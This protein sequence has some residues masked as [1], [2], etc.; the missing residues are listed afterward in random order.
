[1]IGIG[2]QVLKWRQKSWILGPFSD[3]MAKKWNLTMNMLFRVMKPDG[4]SR[5]ILNLADKSNTGFS[6][7]EVLKPEWCTV[8]YI[9]QKEIIE[10]LRALGP[11]SW[12]WAKDLA[13]G[14]YNVSVR[15]ED[16]KHLGFHFDGKTYAFQVI[17]MGLSSSPTIF[18]EYMH[19][20]I[21]AIRN[22]NKELYEVSVP[23]DL[24]NLDHFRS[25][26]DIVHEDDQLIVATIFYYLDDILG[27]H[28]TL[29]GA[30]R[31]WLHSETILRLLNMMTKG[32][33]GRPPAQIQIFLGKEYDTIR[34]WVRISDEKIAK[35]SAIIREVLK[36]RYVDRQDMQSLIG[37]IRHMA[38]VYRPLSAFARGLEKYVYTKEEPTEIHMSRN[39]KRDLKFALWGITEASKFGVPWDYFVAPTRRPIATCYTDASLKIGCG[40]VSSTGLYWQHRW[41]EFKLS[42]S[43]SRD[44]IWRELVAIHTMIFLLHE[45][46]GTA[47]TDQTIAILT[48][49]TPCKYMLISMSAR[50]YRPDLQCLINDV[51]SLLIKHRIHLWIEHVPGKQNIVADALSRFLPVP[52]GKSTEFP[53]YQRSGLTHLR[54]ASD[55]A[56]DWAVRKK[57]LVWI[58][59]DDVAS[60]V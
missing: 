47:L 34:R 21:W 37:K 26:A 13:D 44:I 45:E 6:V 57:Y 11:N 46:M 12:I 7:N 42:S 28:R 4:S 49:N 2:T 40:G 15:K 14:Y 25:F 50:L 48:D 31:Q 38:S 30:Q 59:E 39:L 24:I 8:E 27:G 32:T 55:L 3:K 17:P 10:T 5:P 43:D 35:Y 41:S 58:D 29:E 56:A 18:T 9:Q 36:K 19:F 33:K 23:A 54:R 52:F 20:P 51:C 22:D 53:R 16:V 60:T 1:M